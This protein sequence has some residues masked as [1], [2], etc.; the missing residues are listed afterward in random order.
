MAN[1][2]LYRLIIGELFWGESLRRADYGQTTGHYL[3]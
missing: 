3:A 2:G 1:A